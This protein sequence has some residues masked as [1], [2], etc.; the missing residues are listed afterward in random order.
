MMQMTPQ[1]AWS[2]KKPN[3]SHL[4]VL[5]SIG[6]VHVHDKTRNKLDDKSEKLVFIRYAKNSKGF[7][8]YNHLNET[9]CH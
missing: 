7:K 4:R 6:Y 2:G 8:F 1:E 9:I 5:C 3:T